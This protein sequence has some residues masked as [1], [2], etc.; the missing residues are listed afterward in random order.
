MFW[1]CALLVALPREPSLP[2]QADLGEIG[3]ARGRYRD[4]VQHAHHPMIARLLGAQHGDHRITASPADR[5]PALQ[6][7]PPDRRDFGS[8]SAA[9]RCDLMNKSY[10]RGCR[11]LSRAP[12]QLLRATSGCRTLGR[13]MNIRL[14]KRLMRYRRIS[15]NPAAEGTR[16]G[17]RTRWWVQPG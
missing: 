15:D 4:R 13:S 1:S 17:G 12:V 3:P 8:R 6:V 14:E 16:R 10:K 5:V 9:T 11:R 7:H 2:D